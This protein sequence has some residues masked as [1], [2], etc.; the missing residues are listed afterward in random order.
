MARREDYWHELAN[1]HADKTKMYDK[2]KLAAQ[3]EAN[4]DQTF[5]GEIGNIEETTA[6]EVYGEEN[7]NE[8]EREMIVLTVHAKGSSHGTEDVVFE[9]SFS[10]PAGPKSWANPNFKLKRFLDTY[11][12][13]PEDGMDVDVEFNEDGFLRIAL[14]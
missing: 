12:D 9:D 7:A 10:L 5:I 13:L 8:P 14:E 11:G 3:A 4:S 6:A 2:D 1:E